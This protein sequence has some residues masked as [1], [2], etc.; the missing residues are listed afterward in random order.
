MWKGTQFEGD[1]KL[2]CA[3]QRKLSYKSP[4]S[5]CLFSYLD[6]EALVSIYFE[7]QMTYLW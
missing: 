1:E 4:R 6:R 7:S 3:Q 2:T 5:A